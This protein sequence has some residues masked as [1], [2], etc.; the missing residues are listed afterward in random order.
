MITVLED[1]LTV[2]KKIMW[3][4]P[5]IGFFLST[6]NKQ[7]LFK[8][9]LEYEQIQTA[10]VGKASS[11]INYKLWVNSDFW[12]S[13]SDSL[14]I[15]ILRHEVRHIVYFHPTMSKSYKH[16][17]IF[18]IAADLTVN[19]GLDA[20]IQ[21]S[22]KMSYDDYMDFIE[23]NAEAIKSGKVKAPYRFCIPEDYGFDANE[24]G[25]G[26]KYY[27]DHLLAKAMDK[28][29]QSQGAQNL[30][31]MVNSSQQGN[32]TYISHESW[33]DFENS[34]DFDNELLDN[35]TKYVLKEIYQKNKDRFA[36]N[37]PGHL[38]DFIDDLLKDRPPVFNW[39]AVL[40]QFAAYS[41]D[42]YT[43]SSRRKLNKRVPDFSTI[44]VK[45]KKKIFVGLDTSGSMSNDDIA[46]CFTE[47]H[48]MWRSGTN[49]VV[50]ECDAALD[51]KE[52]VYDYNGVYPKNRKGLS[53]GGGTS[54]DP[55]ISYVNDTQGQYCCFIYLTDGY[56]SQPKVKS[57]IP[58]ITILVPNGTDEEGLSEH[59]KFGK[60]IKMNYDC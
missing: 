15:D 23:K 20:I 40:R 50:G 28:N 58:M 6:L 14:K 10:A 48:H 37:I 41:I 26:T 8:G 30:R 1:V 56:M 18:N 19:Q 39:K 25:K 33:K 38:R 60:V 44:K 5:F 47:I 36:G 55:L 17:E 24:W 7:V 52:D 21:E 22:R 54:C 59:G 43:K 9:D 57:N 51:R 31:R 13:L 16:K 32:P 29:D 42:Y 53:G 45:P 35:Q 12:I 11:S 2:G 34:T 27:Y 3:D 4:W 49:V 46:L